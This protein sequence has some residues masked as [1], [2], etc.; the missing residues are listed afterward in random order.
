MRDMHTRYVLVLG[1]LAACGKEG[2]TK[3]E[4][5]GGSAKNE[6]SSPKDRWL[7]AAWKKTDV[8]LEGVKLTVDVPDGLPP[9]TDYM[10]G[11]DWW[12]GANQGDKDLDF[13]KMAGPRLTL[14]NSREKTFADADALARDVEPDATRSDLVE[15]AKEKLPDGRLRYVSAVKGGSHLDVT[16]WIPVDA[17]HGIRCNAH[18]WMG[19]G[20]HPATAPDPA[21]TEWLGRFCNSVSLLQ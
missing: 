21:I 19:P 20:D 7:K 1:L 5:G 11:K 17:T 15:I 10:L 4:G 12:V 9:N 3:N 2:S 8:D 16:M 6:N 13:S 14:D 18:W